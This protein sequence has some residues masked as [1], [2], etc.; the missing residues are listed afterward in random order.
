MGKP[1]INNAVIG[2]GSMLG[3]ITETGELIRLYWPEI[4][5]SQHIEKMLTG[6]FSINDHTG[7]IWF[8]EGGQEIT[9][10]YIE[11]TNILETSAV[12]QKLHLSVTQTDFCLPD[13]P[14]MVRRYHIKNTGE[15]NFHLGIGLASHVISNHFDMGCSMFD[16]Y[17]DALVHYRHNCCWAITSDA[18]VKEFQIGNNPFGAVWERKLVGID[19]MGM[20]PDGALLW[21]MGVLQPGGEIGLTLHMTFSKTLNDLKKIAAD[22]KQKD[23]NQLYD[24]TKRYWQDFLNAFNNMCTGNDKADRIYERSLLLF[25]LMSDKKSGGI[26]ASPEIDEGFTQCGRYAYCWC[27][28]AAFITRAFDEAGLYSETERF[29]EWALNVQDIEGFWHQRYYMSGGAAP[30]WGIQ[31]DETGT[32]L[33]GILNHFKYVNDIDFLKRM[34]PAVEKAANFLTVFIDDETGLPCPSFD[35]WEER[36]GEHTY[37]TAAVIAGFR[38]AA[39]IGCRLGVS[40]DK[41]DK[42]LKAAENM[43]KALEKE[44]VDKTTGLLLR[45]VRT[46]LN[47]WGAEPSSNT[48]RISVNSKGYSRDVSLTDNRMD[49]SLIGPSVPFG[50]FEYDH[51]VI[52]K[53]V[54]K[55]ENELYCKNA[56]GI[57]RYEGDSYA[58]GNP[59][60]VSTLWLALYYLEAGNLNKASEYFKWAVKCGTHIDLLPEQADKNDGKACWVVPLTWSHAMYVLV[61][62]GLMKKAGKN[63]FNNL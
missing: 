7:T 45:S 49:I 28:D 40:S 56:G 14:V 25:K 26:L 11:R 62:K 21:D 39:E 6:F 17:L 36:M 35:L 58:G 18:E 24:I 53:T 20:S 2:N 30:S 57:Y 51:P 59:W 52:E 12:L 46:K 47:P 54:M 9:Q 23:Y 29:Y 63:I 37:S 38:A 15:D 50:V 44:L 8:S 60:I 1:Y 31:I 43:K 10:R 4:D 33:Y 61:F 55:I 32:I 16:F 41:T 27:R 3:C 48:V 22:V 42:W 34:W 19:S 5:Y 13:S